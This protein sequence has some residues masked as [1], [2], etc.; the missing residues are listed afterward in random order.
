[1]GVTGSILKLTWPQPLSVFNW[2]ELLSIA[3]QLK[4]LV[5]IG[6]FA[7]LVVNWNCIFELSRSDKW[8]EHFSV[9]A[10]NFNLIISKFKMFNLPLLTFAKYCNTIYIVRP[11]HVQVPGGNWF[12]YV[13]DR[14]FACRRN[15]QENISPVDKE[16][17]ETK[18]G[19]SNYY[20]IF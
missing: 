14:Y 2:L 15:V 5:N 18:V 19:G 7:Y 20:L 3:A 4:E 10:V 17:N 12:L 8:N 9:K 6:R 16:R 13:V 1:M 11:F